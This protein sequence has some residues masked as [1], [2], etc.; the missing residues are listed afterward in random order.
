VGVGDGGQGKRGLNEVG[1]K[2][3]RGKRK[4]TIKRK[5]KG[6]KSGRKRRE[7]G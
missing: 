1:N 3:R 5:A 6:E 7:S 4:N 2:E